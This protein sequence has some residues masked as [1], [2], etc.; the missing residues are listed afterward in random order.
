M[1]DTEI[2]HT[3]QVGQHQLRDKPTMNAGHTY[4]TRPGATCFYDDATHDLVEIVAYSPKVWARDVNAMRNSQMVGY[5]VIIKQADFPKTIS[6]FW[7][8]PIQKTHRI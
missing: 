5:Q 7:K 1:A 4:F 3:G 2:G 8:S 6:T